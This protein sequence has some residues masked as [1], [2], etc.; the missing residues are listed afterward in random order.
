MNALLTYDYDTTERTDSELQAVLAANNYMP[1]QS[2]SDDEHM[3]MSYYR[4]SQA[5]NRWAEMHSAMKVPM[6]GTTEFRDAILAKVFTE[7]ELQVGTWNFLS[8]IVASGIIFRFFRIF[9]YFS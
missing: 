2:A 6:P 1:M 5:M 4:V 9:P 7:R 8:Q 3:Q